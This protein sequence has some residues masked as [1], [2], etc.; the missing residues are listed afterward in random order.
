VVVACGQMT[1]RLFAANCAWLDCAVIAHN[2]LRA[3][4]VLAG[5]NHAVARGA[6]PTPGRRSGQPH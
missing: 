6:A 2:L 5:D 3:A 1:S 4:G